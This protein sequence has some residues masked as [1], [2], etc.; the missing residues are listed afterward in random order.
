MYTREIYEKFGKQSENYFQ[1][2]EKTKNTF[3]K[4]DFKKP[5]EREWSRVVFLNESNE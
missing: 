1:V 5:I 4:L 3:F 2:L